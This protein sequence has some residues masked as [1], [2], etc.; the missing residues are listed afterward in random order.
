MSSFLKSSAAPLRTNLISGLLLVA[1]ILLLVSVGVMLRTMGSHRAETEQS[2]REDAVWAAYQLD[3]DTTKL[4]TAVRAAFGAEGSAA[5]DEVSLRFDVLISR[6]STIQ[7]SHFSEKFAKDPGIRAAL[8]EFADALDSARRDL[9]PLLIAGTPDHHTFSRIHREIASLP[10]LSERLLDSVNSCNLGIKVADR[11]VA[12]RRY[13]I[14]TVCVMAMALTLTSVIL[15]LGFQIIQISRARTELQRLNQ[16]YQEAAAAAES[17][18]RAK[19]TFLATMSHEIRTPL[20][21]IIG[22][23]ELLENSASAEEQDSHRDTIRECGQSLIGIIT[24]ILDFSKLESDQLVLE[25]RRFSLAALIDSAIEIVSPRARAK[26]LGLLATYPEARL[27]GDEARLRQV[28]VNLCGNAVKFTPTGDIAIVVSKVLLADGI[29]RLC[30]EVKD[31]GIGISKDSQ[32]RLFQEFTQVDASINRRFGGSGLGLAISRRL[33]EAMGGRIGVDSESGAGSCFW[34]HLPLDPTTSLR[35]PPLPCALDHTRLATLTNLAAETLRREPSTLTTYDRPPASLID[36][37]CL[38]QLS[39][40]TTNI[41]TPAFPDLSHAMIFG[42]GANRYRHAALAIIDGPITS[43][44]LRTLNLASN[45]TSNSTSPE[46]TPVTPHPSAPTNA[47]VTSAN[48]TVASETLPAIPATPGPVGTSAATAAPVRFA[49]RIL[50]VEDNTINQRVATGL[51]K[52]LGV[53]VEIADNGTRAVELATR[54]GFDLVLM[55]MQMPVMDG[56]ESTRRIRQSEPTT[57]R[58]PIVGLTANAF[59]TDREACL[60][61]GMDGFLTKPVSLQKLESTLSPWLRRTLTA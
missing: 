17:A 2:I 56:L 7:Q 9:D 45:P 54:G 31:T 49:G 34:F 32:R 21:G 10:P 3:R 61:A 11:R 51:L 53:E 38:A 44:R 52:K 39:E 25:S 24:D 20:N 26:G 36:V 4:L 23:L 18:S 22:S 15:I 60:G 27:Y 50:L 6:F 28:L 8:G 41:T 33:I 42:Y 47:A 1:S 40:S 13:W 19:S 29:A 5:L 30:F 43:T 55:D 46:N 48:Y 58:T 59:A 12:S 57:H 16:R 37:R 14:L 35:F